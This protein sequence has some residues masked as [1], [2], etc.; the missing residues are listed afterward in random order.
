LPLASLDKRL[1]QAASAAGVALI[2]A[3]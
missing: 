1:C 2:V 3:A